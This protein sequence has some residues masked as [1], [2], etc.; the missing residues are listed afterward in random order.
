MPALFDV[1]G[2]VA[3]VTGG[4]RG[5]GRA[6]AL[7]LA[8]AGARVAVVARS[9]DPGDLSAEMDCRGAEW[10]YLCC[11]LTD[12]ASRVGLVDRVVECFGAIDVLVNNAGIQRK[13]PAATY[14]LSQWDEDLELLLTAAL[15]LSQQAFPRMA[16][17]GWGRVIHIASISSFQGAR[18]IIGYATAKHGIVGLTKCMANEW[19]PHGI[20]VNAIAPGLF[21]TD[22]A[23]AVTA[24][25]V[26]SAELKGRIPSGRFGKPE[27]L[28]GPLLFLASE[29]S[30]HVHGTVLLV[31]GGWMGR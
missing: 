6:M 1:R 22:M 17:R 9:P 11:D 25:P 13:A 20:N 15:D 5:L 31:D 8:E 7:G 12:R 3:M 2:K 14:S 19:A 24:D 4:R 10:L 29:A 26:R 23:S 21:E 16:A 28:V 30:R 27:D 18:E